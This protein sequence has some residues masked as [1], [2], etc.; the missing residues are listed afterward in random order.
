MPD[1]FAGLEETGL[2]QLAPLRR[3]ASNELHFIIERGEDL[4][5]LCRW[6]RRQEYY[7]CTMVASDERMLEDNA[8]KLYYVFSAGEGKF[9]IL[10]HSLRDTPTRYVSIRESFPAVIPL[11]Q[12]AFDLFGLL[13]TNLEDSHTGGTVLHLNA[14]PARLFPL[15]R[16]RPPAN[17]KAR[18]NQGSVQARAAIAELPQG[19]L[20]L[21]VGPIHAGIIEAGHFPFYIAGEVIENLPI[22][23]GYKH[24]G[25]EKLFETQYTLETGWEL[26][27]RVSGDSSFAHSMAYCQAV[28]SLA[29]LALPAPAEAW[30]AMFLEL[31]RIY[32]HIGDIATL[33]HDTAFDLVASAL[34]VV[35]EGMVQLNYRLC[36]QRRL[37]GINRPGGVEL[38]PSPGLDEAQQT[39]P[40]F[41]DRF[42]DLARL[43]LD[44]PAFRE[45]ALTTGVLTRAEAQ[46]LGATGLVRRASGWIDHDFRLRHPQ[47]MYERIDIREMVEK[48]GITG[49]DTH[50][51]HRRAAVFKNDLKGDVFSRLALRVAEVETSFEIVAGLLTWLQQNDNPGARQKVIGESLR[52]MPNFEFGLGYVEGW[53]GD[54]FYWVMKGP[55]N[56]I[57][58]CKVRGPSHF[59]WPV[60]SRAVVPKPG[61]GNPEE[62]Y[63]NILADFPLINKSFNLSYSE[64]DL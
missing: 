31:E 35:A 40:V 29:G 61:E 54:I 13:P 50:S 38:P 11:E 15:K 58:R 10:E 26:A 17:L 39:L 45:R 2:K 4:L 48:T 22:R 23:L 37:R 9:I 12:A 34:S 43:A 47:G 8:F 53:R 62:P 16:T 25:I 24:K 30:R 20:I 41:K 14:Y 52:K 49:D 19:M 1:I 64:H 33:I 63:E 46:E 42:L 21:P 6:A 55:N 7:L 44:H 57:F 56:T 36:G 28:E 59:N 51:T 27:E 5:N 60:L 32:N 3:R 18:L